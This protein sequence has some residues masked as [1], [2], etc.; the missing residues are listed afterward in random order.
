MIHDVIPEQ[1]VTRAIAHLSGRGRQNAVYALRR[2]VAWC[3]N[4]RTHILDADRT[5]AEAYIRYLREHRKLADNT[6]RA[7]VTHIL[8]LYK[9]A[10][11]EALIRS[12]P[13]IYVRTPRAPARSTRPWLAREQVQAMLAAARESLP[14]VDA[15]AHLLVLN[16]PR[17]SE[18]VRI[19]L[20][21]LG[22]HGDLMTVRLP[23]R[24][25]GATDTISVAPETR[26][27]IDRAREGRTTGPLLRNPRFGNRMSTAMARQHIAGVTRAAGIERHITPHD[28]RA[29]FITLSREAGVPDRDLAA[30]SGH[31]SAKMLEYYDRSVGS[32]ERNA[33]HRLSQWLEAP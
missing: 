6:I 14:A 23:L 19:D 30:S 13:M 28:L 29:T 25:N 11:Q 33:T 7:E 12:N 5:L 8:R 32:I 17:V 20:A 2:W 10:H 9:W 27:A 26:R 16:G 4:A 18:V 1:V 3:D 24:K 31:H 21:D 22:T 15:L